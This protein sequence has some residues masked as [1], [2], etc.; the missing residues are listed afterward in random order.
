MIP[1]LLRVGAQAAV[2]AGAMLANPLAPDPTQLLQPAAV[3]ATLSNEQKLVAETWRTVDRLYVDRTMND[4]PNW[5]KLRQ[6]LVKRKYASMDEAY[7]TVTAELLKPLD[8]KYTR[9]LP[10]NRYASLVSS[11]TGEIAGAGV[12]L[13]EQDGYVVVSDV[14]PD[15]PASEVGFQPGDRFLV[16]DGEDVKGGDN[17]RVAALLRGP[18]GTQVGVLVQRG[19]DK[20]DFK[21]KRRTIRIQGV[22]SQVVSV[23]G[24]KVGVIKIKSFSASTSDDVAKALAGFR[25]KVDVLAVDLRNNAGGLLPGGIDTARQ[26]LPNDRTIVTVTNYKGAVDKQ[27]TFV[28]GSDTQ[29]PL[30]LLVNRNTASAA[31]VMTAALQDNDRATVFGETTFG[32]GVIQTVEPLNGGAG[33]AVTIAKYRGPSGRE[34]NKVGIKPDRTLSCEPRQPFAE[35]FTSVGL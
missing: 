18:P 25:G 13:S 12:E 21:I 1:A 4:N 28:D 15:S 26:F 27:T 24:K 9:F 14:Q 2:F 31:E 22:T 10:P 7:D 35:C 3:H 34:I 32:K 33:V 23:D 17:E 8:D 11:A 5:F 16:V 6:D 19:D 20:L 30:V 29:Q